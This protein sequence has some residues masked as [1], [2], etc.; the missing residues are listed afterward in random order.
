MLTQ[1]VPGRARDGGDV[2][3]ATA[4]RRD[5]NVTLRRDWAKG[6]QLPVNLCL[7][8]GKRVGDEVLVDAVDLHE[9][10]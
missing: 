6:I 9:Q 4:S 8:I 2:V 3:D 10:S 7:Y 5:G 1:P